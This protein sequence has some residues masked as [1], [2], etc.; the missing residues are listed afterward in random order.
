MKCTSKNDDNVQ[1]CND[2]SCFLWCERCDGGDFPPSDILTTT[3]EKV[4]FDVDMCAGMH[5]GKQLHWGFFDT[6]VG[7]PNLLISCIPQPFFSFSSGRSD[8]KI[9]RWWLSCRFSSCIMETFTIPLFSRSASMVLKGLVSLIQ[10]FSVLVI[11][12]HIKTSLKNEPMKLVEMK[13]RSFRWL[14]SL[15]V[16]IAPVNL[17]FGKPGV[18]L[19]AIPKAERK[20]KPVTLI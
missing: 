20:I 6:S 8:F 15:S 19:G 13:F 12:D 17:I 16:S 9:S 18:C 5:R 1:V 2:E 10:I 7:K 3:T 4:R 11:Q 14:R